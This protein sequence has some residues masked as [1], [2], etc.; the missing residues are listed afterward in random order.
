M[1]ATMYLSEL[2]DVL[3]E[4]GEASL[5]VYSLL[6]NTLKMLSQNKSITH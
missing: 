4:P 5:E 6:L 3:I 1:A 2:V